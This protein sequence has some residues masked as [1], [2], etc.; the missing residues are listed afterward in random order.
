MFENLLQSRIIEF[1]KEKRITAR[2]Q[3]GFRPQ[4]SCIDTIVFITEFIRTEVDRV[5]LEQAFFIDLQK[6][7]D[8][9][10]PNILLQKMGI[11][12]HRFPI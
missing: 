12:G 3:Y 4:R 9:L 1:R 8:R 5:F 11:F 6:A 10:D 2:T 7:F